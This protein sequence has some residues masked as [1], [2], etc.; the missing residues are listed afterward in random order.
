MPSVPTWG[1]H[2][3][4]IYLRAEWSGANRTL[5]E[6][7]NFVSPEKYFLNLLCSKS[8][9]LKRAERRCSPTPPQVSKREDSR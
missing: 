8:F 5:A 1:K 3:E 9:Q 7:R 6:K 4:F 2:P